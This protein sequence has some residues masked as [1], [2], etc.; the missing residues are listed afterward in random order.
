MKS[1][2]SIL[3]T[4]LVKH[5][6]SMWYCSSSTREFDRTLNEVSA[7]MVF[8]NIWNLDPANFPSQGQLSLQTSQSGP[9]LIQIC[10]SRQYFRTKETD[11]ASNF[12]SSSAFSVL[13]YI[14]SQVLCNTKQFSKIRWVYV[15]L[16]VL[17]SLLWKN[18]NCKFV[19][20]K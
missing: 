9:V 12:Q 19:Q 7:I 4:I 1:H 16:K 2:Y 13:T 15:L 10:I 11:F 8:S 6:A 18:V 14:L 3:N 5:S 20:L 17:I